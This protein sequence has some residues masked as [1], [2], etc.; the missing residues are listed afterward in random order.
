[1]LGMQKSKTHPDNIEVEG[2]KQERFVQGDKESLRYMEW[3]EE[4]C[5]YSITKKVF[6]EQ[7]WYV[8]Y[9]CG[10]KDNSG[11]CGVCVKKCHKG[12]AVAY[13]KRSNFF[14]DCGDSGR[15]KCLN[16]E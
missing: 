15:C 12:H 2:F 9:T 5:T 11:C 13:C 8:C 6:R 14:C 10:L 4:Y 16:K 3:P 1:M 7:H